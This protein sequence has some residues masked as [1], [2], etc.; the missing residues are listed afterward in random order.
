MGGNKYRHR[1]ARVGFARAREE[2]LDLARA[3]FEEEARMG[4]RAAHGALIDFM[5]GAGGRDQE[6]PGG[7]W[8]E[9]SNCYVMEPDDVGTHMTMF[10]VVDRAGRFYRTRSGEHDAHMIEGAD[11]RQSVHAAWLMKTMAKTDW[12]RHCLEVNGW[13]PWKKERPTFEGPVPKHPSK[14]KSKTKRAPKASAPTNPKPAAKP[15]PKEQT[16]ALI[17]VKRSEKKVILVETQQSVTL[18]RG[19]LIALLRQHA[20]DVPKDARIS[21]LGE[22][23]DE[24]NE[25]IFDGREDFTITVEWTDSREETVNL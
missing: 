15:A 5:S 7:C 25:Q 17:D 22:Q 19:E 9:V 23:D 14:A 8:R 2:R 16:V 3:A 1:P 24:G 6:V 21:F 20:G 13:A 10:Y 4:K 12:G 18:K 11:P